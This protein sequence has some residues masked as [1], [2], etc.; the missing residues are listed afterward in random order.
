MLGNVFNLIDISLPALDQVSIDDVSFSSD[1]VHLSLSDGSLCHL[2]LGDRI[3]SNLVS[4]TESEEMEINASLSQIVD[5]RLSEHSK[6][7]KNS[8]SSSEN[9]HS[10]PSE[11]S[12][13][14]SSE[15]V[16]SSH[17]EQNKNSN[18][19]ENINARPS[20]PSYQNHSITSHLNQ[21]IPLR[22]RIIQQYSIPSESMLAVLVSDSLCFYTC[23]LDAIPQSHIKAVKNTLNF[24]I[25]S[26]ISIPLGL[27][28]AKK[29]S[30]I[31]CSLDKS[32]QFEN[33]L[34]SNVGYISPRTYCTNETIRNYSHR[35]RF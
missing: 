11:N 29:K 6:D 30:I 1:D 23:A 22:H 2:S 10:N 5:S 32:L 34:L 14:R 18:S 31:S 33:V 25:D 27:C 12:I 20:Q 13:T 3:T 19:S 24:C 17:S 35:S 15:N 21:R 28:I 26:N 4:G 7:I 9:I 16:H 8:Y